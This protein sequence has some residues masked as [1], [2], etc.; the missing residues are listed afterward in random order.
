MVHRILRPHQDLHEERP[1]RPDHL[2]Y[3]PFRWWKGPGSH[4]VQKGN[5]LSNLDLDLLMRRVGVGSCYD[6]WVNEGK[7][8]VG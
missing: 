3:D 2:H 4:R 1:D 5:F 8:E 7:G 6:R